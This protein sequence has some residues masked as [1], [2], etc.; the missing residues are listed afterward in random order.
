MGGNQSK[1]GFF[2]ILKDVLT[3]APSNE[4]DKGGERGK[5]EPKEKEKVD[6]RF[7]EKFT[8]DGGIFVYC[9]NTEELKQNLKKVC[10]EEDVSFI[11]SCEDE[12]KTLLNDVEGIIISQDADR[13]NVACVWGNCQKYT[14]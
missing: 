5:Y 3:G 10:V 14:L 12:I 7:V 2:S 13:S 9:E 4:P 1:K 11:Y 6:T 8:L